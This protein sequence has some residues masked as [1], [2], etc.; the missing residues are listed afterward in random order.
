LTAVATKAGHDQRCVFLD[1]DGT[2]SDNIFN[3]ASNR[4]EAPINSADLRLTFG[5]CDAL[6]DLKKAGYLLILVSNQPNYALGKS[7]LERMAEVHER[8]VALLDEGGVRLD[9]VYYCIH[10]P[11]GVTPGLSGSCA[12][13]KPSP[14]FINT[15]ILRH[16]IDPARSW[17]IG[18]RPADVGAGVAAGVRTIFLESI[19]HTPLPEGG[20]SPTLRAVTLREAA[21]LILGRQPSD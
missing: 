5:A 13:R 15:A 10:H 9:D 21:D 3:Q 16:G 14:Y 1:R 19:G 4:W 20:V 12:C 17:M 8:L 6:R 18:D 2:I 7:T 11:N